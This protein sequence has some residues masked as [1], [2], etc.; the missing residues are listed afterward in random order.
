[1]DDFTVYGFS[2][3]GCL[4]SLEKVLNRCIEINFVLNFEKCYFMVE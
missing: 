2:F 1:M 3:D 4:N